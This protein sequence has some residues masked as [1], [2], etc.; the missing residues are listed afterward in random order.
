MEGGWVGGQRLPCRP[1]MS[2]GGCKKGRH[3]GALRSP[4]EYGKMLLAG[5]LAARDGTAA[6]SRAG[7]GQ[8]FSPVSIVASSHV[9]SIKWARRL[10]SIEH[11]FRSVA[12]G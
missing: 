11:E 6:R 4:A 7:C 9:V 1:A 8:A 12:I 2:A 10:N 5:D 3:S